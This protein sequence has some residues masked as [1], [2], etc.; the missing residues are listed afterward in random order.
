[1]D[2]ITTVAGVSA[3][4]FLGLSA[5]A[6]AAEAAVLVP[7]WRA[8]RPEAFLAWYR[9]HAALLLKFY[10]PL[11]TAAAV[12]ALG[13]AATSWR[14]HG[15]AAGLWWL[16]A[17]LSVAVLAAFPLYFQRVNASFAA[18]TI[19]PAAVREELRRW[20]LWHWLRVALATGAFVLAVVAIARDRP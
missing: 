3:V 2:L 10:G 5:G 12:S 19:A 7:F 4:V 9:E 14:S 15:Q 11:E 18:G 17:G 20:A 6:V 16:A 8:M 1:M 13:A